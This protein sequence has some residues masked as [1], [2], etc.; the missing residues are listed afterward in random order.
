MQVITTVIEYEVILPR[1]VQRMEVASSTYSRP[2]IVIT[3]FTC[4]EDSFPI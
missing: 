3:S 2:L 1:I 4:L